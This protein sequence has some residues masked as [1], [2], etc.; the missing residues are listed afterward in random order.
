MLEPQLGESFM[1][2]ADG[3][4]AKPT[5]QRLRWQEAVAA[6]VVSLAVWWMGSRITLNPLVRAEQV[7]AMA[8]LQVSV[9][10]LVSVPFAGMV[11]WGWSRG[12]PRW[13]AMATAVA[14]GAS[15]G[16]V[17]G[18]M[19]I[20]LH[21]SRCAVNSL[22]GDAGRLVIWA[23]RPG[24]APSEYPPLP[25]LA[26]RWLSAIAGSP[27]PYVW[28]GLSLFLLAVTG[29]CLYIAWRLLYGP[30][31]ALV[32]GPVVGLVFIDPYKPYSSL[33]LGLSFVVLV[34]AASHLRNG[35]QHWRQ[36]LMVGVSAAVLLLTYPGWFMWMAPGLLIV[37]ALLPWRTKASANFRYL[38]VSG[39]CVLL[40]TFWWLT[41][42][43]TG[44][45]TLRDTFV[46]HDALLR[47]T[48]FA[49]WQEDTPA[50]GVRLPQYGEFGNLDTYSLALIALV[51]LGL[52]LRGRTTVGYLGMAVFV[53][54][55][56][57]KMQIASAFRETGLVQLYPRA[58]MV[59]LLVALTLAGLGFGA[60]VAM[61]A[62]RFSPGR[63][64]LPL[65]PVLLVVGGTLFVPMLAEAVADGYMA[66]DDG[67]GVLTKRALLDACWPI[68][69]DAQPW[70]PE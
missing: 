43:W 33:P 52:V 25:V 58:N 38:V 19:A 26:I 50:F 31:M 32:L 41:S 1:A 57:R 6:L 53:G 21:G 42:A 27:E 49:D 12:N 2:P 10:L 17:A 48:Y 7:S 62:S 65:I 47:P 63:L 66:S 64:G 55:W 70:V 51:S 56:V 69:E 67:K 4:S 44:F 13:L 36:P 15:S 46:Y 29:P 30:A 14:A 18:L 28:R 11:I 5:V 22:G 9:F 34:I 39:G 60:V 40:L 24:T 16:I 8:S 61:A 20:A 3:E 54:V 35:Y 37:V 45:R 23:A 59:M 68:P